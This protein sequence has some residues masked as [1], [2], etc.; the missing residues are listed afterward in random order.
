MVK[1]FQWFVACIEFVFYKYII[2]ID[3]GCIWKFDH[4][5]PSLW[6]NH[7]VKNI[8]Q[9]QNKVCEVLAEVDELNKSISVLRRISELQQTFYNASSSSA[10]DQYLSELHYH[11][12]CSHESSPRLY[13]AHKIEPLIGLTRDP[14]TICPPLPTVPAEL[15]LE[16]EYAV[17]SKRFILMGPSAPYS[18]F[19]YNRSALPP[20]LFSTRSNAR[21]PQIIL[22]DIGSSYFNSR[23]S[24]QPGPH[25]GSRWFYEDFNNKSILLDRIVAFE[26]T[27]LVPRTA[28]EQLPLDVLPIYTLINVGVEE[29]GRFNPWSI[30][31]AITK[32]NDYVLVK[33]DIDE[34]ALEYSL[35]QQIIQS[36]KLQSLIDELFFEMHVT[37]PAMHK[38]WGTYRSKTLADTYELFTQIRKLGIRMH[39]W[40]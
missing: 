31:Q 20:W 36:Q 8:N 13:I 33:L 35:V 29:N 3:D 23:D 34:D 21:T 6:E 7:W 24:A 16:G 32:P 12:S 22:F 28:W 5:A 14:L 15:Y 38:Y 10:T 40:P 19:L 26:Y 39:S 37:V 30:L 25:I 4:Y 17:Q 9:F 11:L 18:N 1:R 2:H 27:P